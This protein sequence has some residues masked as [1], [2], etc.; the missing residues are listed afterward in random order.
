MYLSTTHGSSNTAPIVTGAKLRLWMW[1]AV[2]YYF[3][4]VTAAKQTNNL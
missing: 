3:T 2:R 4:P 1:Y